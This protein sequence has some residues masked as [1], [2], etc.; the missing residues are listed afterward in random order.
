MLWFALLYPGT[1]TRMLYAA[2]FVAMGIAIELLQPYTGRHFEPAD[3]LANTLGVLLGWGVAFL[4]LK[5]RPR[6]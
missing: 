3:M 4:A 6:S 5:W 1:R 2:G